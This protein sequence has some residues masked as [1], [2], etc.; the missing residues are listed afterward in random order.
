MADT[1]VDSL[2]RA[3]IPA[4]VLT[5]FALA[6]RY[7]PAK[8]AREFGTGYSIEELSSRFKARQCS[9]AVECF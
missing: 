8:S 4:I 1:L 6:R 7:F 5:I 2:V 9:S 3:S